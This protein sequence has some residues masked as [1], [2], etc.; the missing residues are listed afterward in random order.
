M[1]IGDGV[2]ASSELHDRA[3]RATDSVAWDLNE[4][5]RQ[6]LC[7]LVTREMNA[8]Y[9]RR[10]E[11]EEVVQSA[12]ATYFR[13]MQNG[14]YV[15]ENTDHLWYLLK[16][17]A[18]NKLRK[19][20][21]YECAGKRDLRREAPADDVLFELPDPAQ[22]RLFETAVA[23]LLDNVDSP[24]REIF[25]FQLLGYD[26]ADAVAHLLEGLSEMH[27]EVLRLRLQGMTQDEIAEEFNCGRTVV[28][29]CLRRLQQRAGRVRDH[30]TS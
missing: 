22:C 25:E 10:I 7:A 1:G 16:K 27:V 15:F 29:N 12:F 17:I 18:T 24:I 11:P 4:R 9:R 13:R 20:I 30:F 8:I 6:R 23:N 14:E 5:F 21:E 28:R 19:R 26:V 2:D 3:N